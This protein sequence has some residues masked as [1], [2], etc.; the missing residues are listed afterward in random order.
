MILDL[1]TE[2]RIAIKIKA[3]HWQEVVQTAGQLL[4]VDNLITEKYIEAMQKSIIENGPYVVIGKGIALLHARPEDGVKKLGMSLVTL[5]EPVNF[6]NKNNDPVKI[7][8]AFGAVDDKQHV[9]AISELST[10]LMADNAV[11]KIA[12]TEKPA[13]ILNYMKKIIAS[14]NYQK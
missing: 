6:G 14:E 10:V 1:L 3:A 7:A 5:A 12:V 8:F 11:N 13:S 9:K 2:G 4:L